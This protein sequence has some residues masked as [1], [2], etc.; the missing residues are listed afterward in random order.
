M[1]P[2]FDILSLLKV[3][4]TLSSRLEA[5]G[6]FAFVYPGYSHVKFGAVLAGRF[7]LCIEG[8]PPSTIFEAGDFYM[9]TGGQPFRLA[10]DPDV[11]PQDGQ[12]MVARHRDPDGVVRYGASGELV[13]LASGGFVFDDHRGGGE[14]SSLLLRHLPPLIRLKGDHAGARALSSVLKLLALETGEVRPG[15]EVAR[16][17]LAT[18]VL[19]QML[20]VYLEQAEHPEGW[21]GA[22][23]DL[24]I[25]AALSRL[26][27]DLGRR[28]TVESLAAEA[29]MS[30]TAFASRFKRLVGSPPLDYLGR[31]RMIVART[32][33]QAG[34]EAIAAI[35]GRIGYQSETAFSTAFK[36]ATGESPGRFRANGRPLSSEEASLPGA[37]NSSAA[38]LL[39]RA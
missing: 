10:S 29:G 7:Q 30:R 37:R 38:F 25:G 22:M 39:K 36:R 24:R 21:L 13:A 27:G 34:E 15:A 14:I 31:W 11:T 3:K 16:E 33:L 17:S 28:W 26:H 32:A 5:R 9:L 8:A 18:L 12:R 2:L 19:V 1:D 23:A 35:A 20:R 6:R 4:S